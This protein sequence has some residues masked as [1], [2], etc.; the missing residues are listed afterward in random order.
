MHGHGGGGGGR[1][2]EPVDTTKLYELLGVEKNAS[3]AD[4]KKAYRKLAMKHHPDKGGDE[5]FFQEL[6]AAHDVLSDPDK[7]AAYD[8]GGME[9]VQGGGGGGEGPSDLFDI[10]SGG[11]RRRQSAP[12]QKKGKNIQHAL[13]M[14]LEEIYCGK[15]RKL[16]MSRNVIDRDYGTK[17]CD[18]C[19]GQGAQ[20]RTVRMG[21][22]IQQIQQPCGA[23]EGKGTR[24]RLNQIKE[25]VEVHVPK[26]APNNHKMTFYE[27]ADEIPDG[28]TG[29]LI[30]VLQEQPHAVFKRKGADLY[31]ERKISLVEALCGFEM[32]LTHLDDRK[33]LIKSAPGDVTKP[34]SFDPFKEDESIK[35]ELME[36][37]DCDLEAIARGDIDD[38]DKCKGVIAK[39]QLK[40]KGIGG[41][42]VRNGKTEFFKGDRDEILANKRRSNGSQLYIH[43]AA[44]DGMRLMKA[45][46][47]EGL[48]VF[49]NSM[50]MG[51]LFLILTIEFP[52]A[53]ELTAQA[54]LRKA[55][56]PPINAITLKEDDPGVDVCVLQGMD[57]IASYK[58]HAI[59]GADATQAD[60]EEGGGGQQGVQCAQQ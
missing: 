17:R 26:G 39:G 30:M 48:P 57:P 29:D 3:A 20:I 9:A 49:K 4:V 32:E 35:W 1:S 43:A 5:G 56:P 50:E 51:N 36:N 55:L 28:I 13:K 6:Q 24:F 25:V 42:V 41:F 18:E 53:L 59:D 27:K 38:V 37:Y 12:G 16:R 21:P 31:I 22:M 58:E 2:R 7:R 34:S 60:E 45:V 14:T 40:G 8:R 23:C 52:D 10:L 15:L 54:A 33:L 11:G 19:N 44:D 47:G 46:K